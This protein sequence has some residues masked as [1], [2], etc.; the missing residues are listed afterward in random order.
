MP[1]T[2]KDI[3][4]ALEG[5][6]GHRVWGVIVQA[7]EKRIMLVRIHNRKHSLVLISQKAAGKF[8]I[9]FPSYEY[10]S[11]VSM[12]TNAEGKEVRF[13]RDG[14]YLQSLMSLINHSGIGDCII[15]LKT[16]IA[17]NTEYNFVTAKDIENR[18]NKIMTAGI[19]KEKKTKKK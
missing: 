12:V 2:L 3:A 11:T 17:E 14:S 15:N 4:T 6:N 9:T 5:A 8:H 18:R 16:F 1:K 10:V 13:I 7:K 19:K